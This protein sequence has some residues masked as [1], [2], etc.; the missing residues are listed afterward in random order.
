MLP[1]DVSSNEVAKD[2]SL[3]YNTGPLSRK[4][5]FNIDA[6]PAN[7]TCTQSM[8]EVKLR[9]YKNGSFVK[10]LTESTTAGLDP[11]TPLE[12]GTQLPTPKTKILQAGKRRACIARLPC[13]KFRT[14]GSQVWRANQNTIATALELFESS[15]SA[16]QHIEMRHKCFI[17][18]IFVCLSTLNNFIYLFY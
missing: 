16:W 10:P 2:E 17:L 14:L 18:H 3:T 9:T 12:T 5:Y 6:L 13:I 1:A 15:S 11:S 7:Y 4:Q 8:S